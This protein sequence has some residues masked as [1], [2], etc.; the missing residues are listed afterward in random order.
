MNAGYQLDFWTPGSSPACAISRT[1]IRHRPNLRN[2]ECGRP[3]FWQR[4]YARTANFGF[5]LAL[6]TSA[7]LAMGSVLLEREAEVLEQRTAFFVVGGGGHDGDV[8][9]ARTIDLVHVDLVEH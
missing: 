5:L 2:T 6:L 7:F 9:T 1:Q 3:H 4:V 8:H